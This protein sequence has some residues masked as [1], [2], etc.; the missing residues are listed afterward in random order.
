MS[1][2]TKDQHVRNWPDCP[3]PYGANDEPRRN[4]QLVD[5][6]A[7]LDAFAA[8]QALMARCTCE[9]DIDWHGRGVNTIPAGGCPVHNE[10]E[11]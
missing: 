5:E 6:G 11:N 7:M 3:N 9:W 10:E 4:G 2:W 1:G 8:H